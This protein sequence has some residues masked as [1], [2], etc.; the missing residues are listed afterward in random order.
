MVLLLFAGVGSYIIASSNAEEEPLWAAERSVTVSRSGEA[1]IM[2]I[3]ENMPHPAWNNLSTISPDK[4]ALIYSLTASPGTGAAVIDTMCGE[5][6]PVCSVGGVTDPGICVRG[7]EWRYD[8]RCM[9]HVCIEVPSSKYNAKQL[10]T[11]SFKVT[12]PDITTYP[13]YIGSTI[14][15]GSCAEY[16]GEVTK[17]FQTSGYGGL[18][19]GVIIN[20][21]GDEGQRLGASPIGNGNGTNGD[22]ASRSS[23]GGGASANRVADSSNTVPSSSSQGDAPATNDIQPDPF[24]D[25]K[26][27]ESGSESVAGITQVGTK[28]QKLSR[29][30][31]GIAAGTALISLAILAAWL[32][33]RKH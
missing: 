22:A 18:D 11:V 13:F 12:A 21:A 3:T 27:Y 31:I 28:K 2:K 17:A 19:D 20:F 5:G 26:Q 4:V 8:A 10:H 30:V 16:R 29:A 15:P 24:F 23:S 7:G 25:G 14:Y 1:Y 33:R 32:V 9:P 6:W